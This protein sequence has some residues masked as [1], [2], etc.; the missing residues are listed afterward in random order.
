MDYKEFNEAIA[1]AK[2]TLRKADEAVEQTGHLMIGRLRKMNPY[3]LAKLKK[4]LQ[5]FNATTKS[6]K[7]T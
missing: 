1:E 4:E 6:W 7:N 2:R 5:D 3:Y